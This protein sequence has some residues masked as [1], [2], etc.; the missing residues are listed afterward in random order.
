MTKGID[1]DLR[2]RRHTYDSHGNSNS[3]NSPSQS[4]N[5][6]HSN[7]NSHGNSDSV[8]ASTGPRRHT[9]KLGQRLEQRSKLI[10]LKKEQSKLTT[11]DEQRLAIEANS[12]ATSTDDLVAKDSVPHVVYCNCQKTFWKN[13]NT[14][15][16]TIVEHVQHNCIEVIPYYLHNSTDSTNSSTTTYDDSNSI[17]KGSGSSAIISN[18]NSDTKNCSSGDN[19]GTH[20]NYYETNFNGSAYQDD[21][22]MVLKRIYLIASS[23][24]TRMKADIVTVNELKT[25]KFKAEIAAQSL[26]HNCSKVVYE[27]DKIDA[28]SNTIDEDNL[29]YEIIIEMITKYILCHLELMNIHKSSLYYLDK[30]AIYQTLEVIYKEPTNLAHNNCL[31]E[32]PERLI[33]YPY[34]STAILTKIR[35]IDV[36]YV[37][38]I[39]YQELIIVAIIV[40]HIKYCKLLLYQISYSL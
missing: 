6:S 12:K 8:S 11:T 26:Y 2:K 34:D 14:I 5:N 27:E 29:I 10:S 18:S 19:R 9:I 38:I 28:F 21:D 37:L 39:V 7:S 36:K 30:F 15:G 31:C 35:D 22:S 3:V 16:V 40:I 13:G 4:Y 24:R 25:T 20:T 1:E 32:K 33:P 17:H 23:I